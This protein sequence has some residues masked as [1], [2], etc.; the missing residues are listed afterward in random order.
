MTATDEGGRQ[1]GRRRVFD[2]SSSKPPVPRPWGT[3]SAWN[4]PDVAPEELAS[5]TIRTGLRPCSPDGLPYVGR[6]ARFANLSAAT[7]HAMMGVSLAP[8]TGTLIAQ[9]L[10]GE[11]SSIAIAALSPDRYVRSRGEANRQAAGAIS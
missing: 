3:S 8:I 6:F 5:A 10:S 1:N 9:I 2:V 11:T 4:I 7:G